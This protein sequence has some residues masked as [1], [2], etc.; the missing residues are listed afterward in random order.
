MKGWNRQ[1]PAPCASSSNHHTCAS[2]STAPCRVPR[3]RRVTCR[4]RPAAA[5]Q[6]NTS[7]RPPASAVNTILAGSAAHTSGNAA[8]YTW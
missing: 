7:H 6:A 4:A 5:S 3:A 8:R 2:R 1:Q